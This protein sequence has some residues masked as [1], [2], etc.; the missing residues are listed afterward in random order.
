VGGNDRSF[1]GTYQ[2]SSGQYHMQANE[3][4]DDPYDGRFVLVF[5]SQNPDSMKGN[6]IPFHPTE[7]LSSKTFALSRN[8]FK[9]LVD[10]GQYPQASKVLLTEDDVNNMMKEDLQTMRNEIFAR[11]GYCFKRKELREQFEDKDWYIPYTVD[12]R[13]DLT[14]IEKR[15]SHSSKNLNNMPKPMEMILEDNKP[16]VATYIQVASYDNNVSAAMALGLLKQNKINCHL[17]D[18]Y[19]INI[20]PLLNPAIGG[21]KLMVASTDADE[22]A[23]IIRAAAHASYKHHSLFRLRHKQ[24]CYKKKSIPCLRVFGKE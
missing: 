8:Q 7:K 5:D 19:I 17:R 10:V 22:A 3:P 18:E 23:A 13:K 4:G 21:I 15:I 9:Y 2:Y 14:E 12:I 1:T 20:D 24:H 11:H 16:V 6:W